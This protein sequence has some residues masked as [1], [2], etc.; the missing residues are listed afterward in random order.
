M[1]E[2]INDNMD[3][4]HTAEETAD[5]DVTYYTLEEVKTHNT[6]TDA[7]LIIHDKVYNVTSFLQEHP[8]GVEIVM[9]EAGADATASFEAV[10]HSPDAKEMLIQFYIGELQMDDR[11]KDGAKEK[12]ISTKDG[13]SSWIT[14]LMHAIVAVVVGI[15]QRCYMKERKSS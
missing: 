6:T 13:S 1:A 14:W 5:S 3:V 10:G 8:G 9:M 12:L 15:M 2:E 11:K 7:W 4:T